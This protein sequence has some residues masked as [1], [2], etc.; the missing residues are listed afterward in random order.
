MRG[1][2]WLV[3]LVS[4]APSGG[5]RAETE[6]TVAALRGA[7]RGVVRVAVAD[8]FVR[9]DTSGPLTD[10][11]RLGETLQILADKGT[12]ELLWVETPLHYRGF[13]RARDLQ[14]L[15]PGSRAYE[16]AAALVVQARFANLYAQ[17]DVTLR[18]PLVVAPLGAR[19]QRRPPQELTPAELALLAKAEPGRWL[20][21]RLPDRA[22]AFV[23]SG[24]VVALP[25]QA[26]PPS[27]ACVLAEAQRHEGTPY[28][29]GGR[30]TYGI[31]CSGLTAN[32]FQACGAPLP[33]DAD[34]QAEAPELR[35]ASLAALAPGDLLFFGKREP[36]KDRVTHVGIYLG[37]GEFLHATPAERPVVHRSLLADPRWQRS[38][39]QARRHPGLAPASTSK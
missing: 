19:L 20:A 21:V 5:L 23:Q 25:T 8:L 14:P 31:D 12:A 28:L 36:P 6:T 39:L 13:A 33:R 1:S 2:L 27:V 18:N 17:P 34:Q 9:P 29:W 22:P 3:L 35:P 24:D 26:P 10:Q 32:A 38:L 11:A 7:G 37:G 16:Q 15:P 30:S 4:L